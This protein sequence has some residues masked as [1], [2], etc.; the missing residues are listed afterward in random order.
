MTQVNLLQLNCTGKALIM[1]RHRRSGFF[2]RHRWFAC[3]LVFIGFVSLY[4]AWLIA[5]FEESIV[6]ME[7]NPVGR[8]LLQINNG[9]SGVF[10]RVKLAGTLI[11]LTTL[12][13][14]RWQESRAVVPVTTSISSF[15]AGLLCYLTLI[16]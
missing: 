1:E 15:Q 9:G 14:M 5:R 16:G 13:I 8:W 10:I 12:L 7:E 4:D 3:A 6:F 11:V 2:A